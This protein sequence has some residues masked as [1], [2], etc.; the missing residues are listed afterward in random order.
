MKDVGIP[1]HLITYV[2]STI[3]NNVG[4]QTRRRITYVI[5]VGKRIFFG[6]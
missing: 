4:L 1:K 5:D 3:I 6:D 2:W